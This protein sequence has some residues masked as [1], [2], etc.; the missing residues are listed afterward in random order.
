MPLST[1]HELFFNTGRLESPKNALIKF[2][3]H[4]YIWLFFFRVKKH[5]HDKD[6]HLLSWLKGQFS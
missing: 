2:H 6:L 4:E 5:L 3:L 1:Q